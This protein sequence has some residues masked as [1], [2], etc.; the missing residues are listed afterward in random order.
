MEAKKVFNEQVSGY[1]NQAPEEHRLIMEKVRRLVHDNVHGAK[2]EYKWSR[3]VFSKG[4]DFLYLKNSKSYVT[5]GFFNFHK[6]DDP[7]HL[8]EGTGKDMRHIKVK[9]QHDLNESLLSRW[10]I[11]L[12]S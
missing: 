9:Q 5:V 4:I 11:K 1:I 2:E 7:D 12:T 6:L 3:P 8:L 10:L